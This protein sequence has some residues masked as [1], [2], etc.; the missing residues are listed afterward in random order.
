MRKTTHSAISAP[1]V[2]LCSSPA[3]VSS[4]LD[5][6]AVMARPNAESRGPD[7]CPLKCYAAL[8]RTRSSWFAASWLWFGIAAIGCGG[9]TSSLDG[10]SKP[11][12][13]GADSAA[14][15]A[16]DANLPTDGSL[17]TS[18]EASGCVS[19]GGSCGNNGGTC[20]SP[21]VCNAPGMLCGM[22]EGACPNYGAPCQTKSDCCLPLNCSPDGHCYSGPEACL[23]QGQECSQTTD[24]CNQDG[25]QC[26][27]GT[28]QP[29]AAC[30]ATGDPCGVLQSV[31]R[32][33][34]QPGLSESHCLRP[35]V[36]QSDL[37]A[38]VPD[39]Q[40]LRRGDPTHLVCVHELRE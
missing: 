22:N 27:G 30:L 11:V 6:R 12:D 13:A 15:V 21:A 29:S 32:L 37:R 7:A 28:C 24:G 35:S 34:E 8:M 17:D 40:S 4:R 18:T 25:L 10:T 33:P 16:Q 3:L 23:T 2:V 39:G 14:D 31:C 20:C 26:I 19:M 38:A 1:S 5:V 36:Q 9:S